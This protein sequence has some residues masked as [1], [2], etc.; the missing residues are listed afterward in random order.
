MRVEDASGRPLPDA[1]I[2][3][4]ALAP[5]IRFGSAVVAERLLGTSADDQRYRQEFLRRFT[6]AVPENALKWPERERDPELGERAVAWLVAQGVPVRGHALVWP[7]R[8]HLPADLRQ[9]ADDPLIISE[10]L[11]RHLQNTLAAFRGR[12]AAWDVVNDPYSADLLLTGDGHEHVRRWFLTAKSADPA[13]P[14]FLN[15]YGVLDDGG[16]DLRR[17]EFYLKLIGD[18]LASGTPI[19]GLGLQC[20]QDRNLTPPERL[21]AII[22]RFAAFGLPIHI[23][24]FDVDLD[25]DQLQA[26]YTRDAL[27][28]FYSQPAVQAVLAWGFWAGDHHRPRAAMLRKDWTTSASGQ[29]WADLVQGAWSG[30]ASATSDALGR[31]RI[32]T[33][34]GTLSLEARHQGRSVRATITASTGEAAVTLRIANP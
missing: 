14:R 11:D 12:L 1:Q 33:V 23:T 4:R 30:A 20:H 15:L 22:E 7:R 6:I 28:I 26:D 18:L 10:R 16:A 13:T 2:Q 24:E 19:D 32:T 9:G 8:E 3:V 5:A 31:C 27:T 34:R 25:D 21:G 29:P 17:Q